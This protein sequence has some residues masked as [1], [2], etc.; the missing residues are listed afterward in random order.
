MGF[1]VS[2]IAR[3]CPR[4]NGG[5]WLAPNCAGRTNLKLPVQ[6]VACDHRRLATI[7]ARTTHVSNLCGNTRQVGQTRNAVL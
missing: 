5:H 7:S 3:H 4:T 6:R 1:D 2:D